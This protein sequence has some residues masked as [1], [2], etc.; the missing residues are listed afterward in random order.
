MNPKAVLLLGLLCF[1]MVMCFAAFTQPAYAQADA[2][3]TGLGEVFKKRAPTGV[4]PSKNQLILVGVA[5]L[6]T[7]AVVKYL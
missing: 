3:K 7:I 6:V 2:P 4:G 1:V 5:T